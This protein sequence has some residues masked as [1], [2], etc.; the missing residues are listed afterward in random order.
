MLTEAVY[1]VLLHQDPRY[2]RRGT[3][4]TWRRMGYAL[5]RVVITQRDGGG[6]QFNTSEWLG[7]ATTVGIGNA[8]Y[9]D[10]RTIGGN[11]SRLFIQVGI[12]AASMVLKE[13]WPDIRRKMGK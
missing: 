9:P 13:F 7:N 5:T 12:D 11:T 4:S 1:P 8:Y 10:S 6:S 3:G 2:F